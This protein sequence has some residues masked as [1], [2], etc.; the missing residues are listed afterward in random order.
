MIR[1]VLH[2]WF[3]IFG[4]SVVRLHISRIMFWLVCDMCTACGCHHQLLPYFC[5]NSCICSSSSAPGSL[6][7]QER[8]Q[9]LIQARIVHNTKV[10]TNYQHHEQK[11]S[12]A[13]G[14]GARSRSHSGIS[15]LELMFRV[16]RKVIL[17]RHCF[18]WVECSCLSHQAV[19]L[20]KLQQQRTIF[21]WHR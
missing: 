10:S 16:P 20:L 5:R 4:I 12:E 7:P 1:L 6:R 9:R 2:S 15:A 21:S 3:N 11:K 8:G 17:E 19:R 14:H 18:R 13:P